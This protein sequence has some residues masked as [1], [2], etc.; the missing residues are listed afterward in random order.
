MRVSLTTVIQTIMEEVHN[1]VQQRKDRIATARSRKPPLKVPML[2][3]GPMR[4]PLK[5]SGVAGR[6]VNLA[7]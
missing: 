5:T 2:D 1:D 4:L 6:M 7:V 3:G